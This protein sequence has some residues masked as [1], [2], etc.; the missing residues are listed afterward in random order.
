MSRVHIRHGLAKRCHRNRH[1]SLPRFLLDLMTSIGCLLL[2]SA[3]GI[4]L[5]TRQEPLILTVV[6]KRHITPPVVTHLATVPTLIEERRR[7]LARPTSKALMVGHPSATWLMHWHGSS[8]LNRIMIKDS[9]SVPPVA[10]MQGRDTPQSRRLSSR[11][12]EIQTLTVAFYRRY[13]QALTQCYTAVP[14]HLCLPQL[15]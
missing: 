14:A 12:L 6:G 11:L 13:T 1:R 7:H 3:P 10:R 15:E 5:P 4:C 8:L 2:Q 9:R